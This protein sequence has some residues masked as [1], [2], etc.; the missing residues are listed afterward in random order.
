MV[1]SFPTIK[2]GTRRMAPLPVSLLL[3][4]QL[5]ILFGRLAIGKGKEV[6]IM[7]NSVGTADSWNQTCGQVRNHFYKSFADLEGSNALSKQSLPTDAFVNHRLKVCAKGLTCCTEE[8]ENQF[9]L[10]S[11]HEFRRLVQDSI[12]NLVLA[13][14]SRTNG[15]DRFFRELLAK[16]Q[17]DLHT[18]FMKTYGI[19][20]EQ[21]SDLFVS[22][23]DNLTSYYMYKRK[24]DGSVLASGDLDFV[25][26]RF[27]ENLYRRMFR[28]L[29]QPYQL[30][31]D[32]WQ[33]M[34]RHMHQLQPFGQVP[35]KMKLQVLKAFSA[36]RT[37]IHALTVGSDVISDMLKMKPSTEC[38]SQL[39]QMLYCPSCQ[40]LTG[41]KPCNSFCLAITSRCLVSYV[42]FDRH[43]NEYLESLLQLL[44]RLEGPYN[45]ESVINP[46]DIQISEAIMIFQDRGKEISDKVFAGCGRPKITRTKRQSRS[47]MVDQLKDLRFGPI[48]ARPSSVLGTSMDLL[49]KD[50][51]EKAIPTKGFW[52][53]LPK[54]LCV[55]FHAAAGSNRSDQYCWN[56]TSLQQQ[57][58]EPVEV[59]PDQWDAE[60]LL[61]DAE[62][63][64]TIREMVARIR[65][66][67]NELKK[68]MSF[69][70]KERGRP[71]ASSAWK[72]S[73][74]LGV[75]A[76]SPIYEPAIEQSGYGSNDLFGSGG[77]EPAA[78][79]DHVQTDDEDLIKQVG[80]KGV[81][82]GSGSGMGYPSE[83][84]VTHSPRDPMDVDD[85]FMTADMSGVQLTL[86]TYRPP[87]W[88][89]SDGRPVPDFEIGMHTTPPFILRPFSR[90][91]DY[92]VFEATPPPSSSQRLAAYAYSVFL[93][94]L[95]LLM[96][97]RHLYIQG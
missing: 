18:M 75:Q 87:P 65:R 74:K 68:V 2:G 83:S 30:D 25:M 67:V 51:K 5:T 4:C 95:L 71:V 72:P 14:K 19:L 20:Y 29:N 56:G 9:V 12:M 55:E 10:R 11:Q 64:P 24:A 31:E 39:T 46:I 28:M 50:M 3:Y 13:F 1:D 80:H 23:F 57:S 96:A 48:S 79:F 59:S 86:A 15:F 76:A 73:A 62:I 89:D 21:N 44:D 6:D 90:P 60:T 49:A 88:V 78:P 84:L 54:K 92:D 81:D 45:I 37:F 52:L 35:E 27:Y 47:K 43:W 63:E 85:L 38:V 61:K 42:V 70:P 91:R 97:V 77:H 8:M 32:Y 41:Q 66:T 93:S 53:H 34:S 26:D 7:V 17:R 33:C 36:A 82:Q 40:G 16:S 22:L 58:E 69:D 94:T